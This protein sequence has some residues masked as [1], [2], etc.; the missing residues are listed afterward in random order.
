VSKNSIPNIWIAQ[1][2]VLHVYKLLALGLGAGFLVL[3]VVAV[4]QSFRSPIVVVRSGAGQEFYPSDRKPAPLE[5][6]DVEIFTK[7]FLSS[8]YAWKE[9]S[10]EKVAREIA[11]FSEDGLIAK[12]I[13]AQS[14][15][16]VKELKDKHLAQAITFVQIDVQDA[17]VICRFDRVLKIEGI[18]LVIPTEVTLFLVQREP[19][20][21]NPMGIYVT[22]ILES[23]NAK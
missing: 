16:Y 14:Q 13:D 9:F 3:L 23:D 11:P 5:K 10:G 17:K 1:E 18:P 19:T 8:L 4:A 6:A 20:R 7:H 21:L 15:K 22:G 2:K 12:V